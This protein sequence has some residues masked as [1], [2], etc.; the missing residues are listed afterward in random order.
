MGVRLRSGLGPEGLDDGSVRRQK[1][2]FDQVDAV[3][4]RGKNRQQ[5]ISNQ[6]FNVRFPRR[7][8][9]HNGGAVERCEAVLT[10]WLA[11]PQTC[12]RVVQFLGVLQKLLQVD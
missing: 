10:S 4:N 9:H 6:L 2:P 5:A 1:W 11:R 8:A 7:D 3:G 12:V